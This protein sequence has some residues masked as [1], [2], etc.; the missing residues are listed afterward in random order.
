MLRSLFILIVGL[1]TA[2]SALADCCVPL[3][4]E[5]SGVRTSEGRSILK[6]RI[7]NRG[8][9]AITIG[10]AQNPWIGPAMIKVVAMRLPSG[11]SVVNKSRAVI[12]PSLVSE[13][14]PA[15]RKLED[16][17][18]LDE[19][20]PEVAAEIRRG[21]DDVIVFWTYRFSGS[22]MESERLGGWVLFKA[23]ARSREK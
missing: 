20:Y 7:E 17:V 13:Q 16:V 23:S 18:D 6:V 3:S 12:D 14:L 2:R 8:T 15:G 11:A 5:V 19:M 22:D 10:P 4:V 9:S 1:C 21:K